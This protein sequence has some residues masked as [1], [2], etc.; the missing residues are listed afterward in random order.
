MNEQ[1][2]ARTRYAAPASK[3]A[4]VESGV[5]LAFRFDKLMVVD[6]KTGER[7]PVSANVLEYFRDDVIGP[8][9]ADK[10]RELL[11]LGLEHRRAEVR[12][13]R[14]VTKTK[15]PDVKKRPGS[16]SVSPSLAARL[17]RARGFAQ[18]KS[19][20]NFAFTKKHAGQ[21]I[22]IIFPNREGALS[23]L[24]LATI[25][26]R[27]QTAGLAQFPG[28]ADAPRTRTGAM[29]STKKLGAKKTVAKKVTRTRA[30]TKTTPRK[31]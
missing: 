8:A 23:A 16:K 3:E 4:L 20:D 18:A 6:D 15:T 11:V 30:P 29:K 10:F 9:I 13:S 24:T 14:R 25:N 28:S 21:N 26:R 27:L 17:L 31:R 12:A 5:S 19:G 22:V 2:Q 7:V 1:L